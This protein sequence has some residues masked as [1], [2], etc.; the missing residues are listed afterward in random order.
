MLGLF[1]LNLLFSLFY[2]CEWDSNPRPLPWLLDALPVT[3]V[4]QWKNFYFVGFI[5]LI[6]KLCWFQVP[7]LVNVDFADVRAIMAD[8]G[9]SLMGIGTATGNL[10][11]FAM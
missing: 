9:S 7:G 8:A 1:I 3:T 10:V 11:T 2:F 4:L 5:L 6:S